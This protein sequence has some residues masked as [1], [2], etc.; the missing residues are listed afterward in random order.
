V[1][2]RIANNEAKLT[3]KLDLM[4]NDEELILDDMCI[5]EVKKKILCKLDIIDD[6]ILHKKR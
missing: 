1:S 2:K 4:T 6:I 5:M 3:N